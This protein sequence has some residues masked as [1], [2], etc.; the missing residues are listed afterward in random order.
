M[1]QGIT[2]AADRFAVWIEAADDPDLVWDDEPAAPDGGYTPVQNDEV[3]PATDM[4][5]LMPDGG[6]TITAPPV[7]IPN[8]NKFKTPANGLKKL[9]DTVDSNTD[10]KT[11]YGPNAHPKVQDW[12][13]KHPA[14]TKTYFK[15]DYQDALK[16]TLGDDNYAKLLYH[17][18]KP[19]TQALTTHVQHPAPNSN[20]FKTPANGLS[21]L[22][23]NPET[24]PEHVQAWVDKHPAFAKGYLQN[25]NYQDAI[26]GV[27]GE[28]NYKAWA[29][30]L[31]LPATKKTV[32]QKTQDI[33]DAFAPAGF[34]P[35][36]QDQFFEDHVGDS[37]P[38]PGIQG[39]M[40]PE[41]QPEVDAIKQQAVAEGIKAIFP[42]V[43]PSVAT[44]P[45]DQQ[46]KLLEGW[47]THL[48]ETPGH[49]DNLVKLKALYD[50]H[51][52]QTPQPAPVSPPA[53]PTAPGQPPAGQF[54]AP[55]LADE[56]AQIKGYDSDPGLNHGGVLWSGMSA[57]E[58]KSALGELLSDSDPSGQEG[59]ELQ[60]LYNKHFGPAALSP[61]DQAEA[62]A[63]KTQMPAAGMTPY[64]PDMPHLKKIEDAQPGDVLTPEFVQ[65]LADAKGMSATEWGALPY[66]QLTDI[67]HEYK[68]QMP[69]AT[70]GAK[71]VATPPGFAQ[72]YS[73][74]INEAPGAWYDE[75]YSA[76]L[77]LV[78]QYKQLKDYAN[79]PAEQP[80][81]PQYPPGFKAWVKYK[82][83]GGVPTD[84]NLTHWDG[85]TDKYKAKWIKKEQEDA[86]KPPF[87][88][89]GQDFYH[90]VVHAVDG[91]AQYDPNWPWATSTDPAEQ[92]AGLKEWLDSFST[93]PTTTE[94]SPKFKQVY[95]KYFGPYSD[96]D[97]PQQPS[98][99][100]KPHWW[101]GYWT[102]ALQHSIEN[103]DFPE[104][105]KGMGYNSQPA[106]LAQPVWNELAAHY[107]DLLDV[108]PGGD[109]YVPPPAPDAAQPVT[110]DVQL[111]KAIS[112][113]QLFD[114]LEK[115]LGA[116]TLQKK[117]WTGITKSPDELKEILKGWI[118]GAGNAGS[119]LK[120]PQLQ[121]AKDI[122]QKY[123]GYM[124]AGSGAAQQPA[125]SLPDWLDISKDGYP[126]WVDSDD[127][128][129]TNSY[130][131][132]LQSWEPDDLQY[133]AAHP[134]QAQKSWQ[135]H[136][137]EGKWLTP[138][139][140][141]KVEEGG[142]A[143]P[144]TS[145][146]QLW[147]PQQAKDDWLS[148]WTSDESVWDDQGMDDP[149][150]AKAYVEALLKDTTDTGYKVPEMKAWLAK[151]F[152]SGSPTPLSHDYLT[153]QLKAADDDV[154]SGDTLQN[155]L[156]SGLIE[157]KEKLQEMIAGG[158]D[159]LANDD[160]LYTQGEVNIYK[161]LLQQLSG[162]TPPTQQTGLSIGQQLKKI[163]N[164]YTGTLTV[165]KEVADAY[166]AKSPADL[167]NVIVNIKDAYPALA[168]KIQQ[169]Y[170]QHISGMAQS[171]TG[172]DPAAALAEWNTI[173]PNGNPTDFSSA[174]EAEKKVHEWQQKANEI[175]IPSP[176]LE[177]KK[178]KVQAFYDKWFGQ[179]VYE[180]PAATGGGYFK[181]SLEELQALNLKG[182][183]S[184]QDIS[185]QTEEEF[186]NNYNIV[187]KGL[188][189]GSWNYGPDDN[190]T[191][192]V[193]YIDSKGG[194]AGTVP[195]SGGVGWAKEY[196]NAVNWGAD[197]NLA[198]T[199]GLLFKDMTPEQAK[200]FLEKKLADG[201]YTADEQ[202][203]VQALYD[204]YFGSGGAAPAPAQ[205]DDYL[206]EQL[207]KADPSYWKVNGPFLKDFLDSDTQAKIQALKGYIGMGLATKE[208]NIYKQ[209]LQQLEG[210]MAAPAPTGGYDPVAALAE[211]KQIFPNAK[212]PDKFN[213]PEDA[214][215]WVYKNLNNPNANVQK[216]PQI[217]AFWDKWFGSGAG[218]EAAP[219]GYVSPGG[220][221]FKPSVDELKAL[222]PDNIDYAESIGSASDAD[223]KENYDYVKG[224]MAAG[225]WKFGDD[226]PWT[227]IVKYIDSKTPSETPAFAP[228]PPPLP[229]F[230]PAAFQVAYKAMFP[231]SGWDA[232]QHT[233]EQTKAKMH[234]MVQTK[235]NNF[236]YNPTTQTQIDLYEK[237]FG[238]FT[239]DST[240]KPKGPPPPPPPAPMTPDQAYAKLVADPENGKLF[241]SPEFKT[242]FMQNPAKQ[243]SW[244]TNP[245]L[246]AVAYEEATL[247]PPPPPMPFKSQPFKP[248]EL[249]HWAANKPISE[250]GW[251]NF[252]TWWANT[253]IPPEQEQAL[254]KAWFG[255]D[256]SP[257]QAG[258]WFQAMFELHAQPSEGDLGLQAG[259]LPNWAQSTWAF[260]PHAAQEWPV[261][262]A[263]ATKDPGIPAGTKIRQKLMIWNSLSPEDKQAI[264]DNYLPSD[265]VD[266]QAVIGEL[267]KAYPDSDW[268]A[269][270]QMGQ[271]TLKTN[272]R[273]LAESG[274]YPA[275]TAAFNKYFGGDIPMPKPGQKMKVKKAPVMKLPD[276]VSTYDGSYS[277]VTNSGFGKPGG[278][279]KFTD[280]YRWAESMGM[281]KMALGQE[282]DP[283][284]YN[285]PRSLLNDWNAI[286]GALKAAMKTMP[287][288]PWKNRDEFKQW[289]AATQ[290]NVRD[291]V[292]KIM[293]GKG[294]GF[295]PNA[296]SENK[297][298]L[299]KF[300]LAQE[301]GP[302]KQALL[303]VYNKHYGMTSDGT[304]QP[305]LA[306]TL[307]KIEP[308]PQ[309]VKNATDWDTYLQ[310]TPLETVAK[311]IKKKIKDEQDPDKFI[312]L[313]D[314]WSQ[315]F[316][317]PAGHK[318]FSS[319]LGQG[320]KGGTKLGTEDL[321]RLYQWKASGSP[322]T[323]LLTYWD[324][325]TYP[326]AYI[327]AVKA[328]DGRSVYGAAQ[329]PIYLGWTPP[330]DATSVDYT[331]DPALMGHS[332]PATTYDVPVL[333]KGQEYQSLLDSVN[334]FVP[335]FLSP[336]DKNVLKSDQFQNWF[337]NAS[338]AYKAQYKDHPGTAVS[339]FEK[340][341]DQ[342]GTTYGPV[343]G[344]PAVKP[345]VYDLSPFNMI[346]KPSDKDIGG[347][348]FKKEF[349]HNPPR[350]D[351]V[352]F[353]RKLDPQETLPLQPGDRW[354]PD[355]AAMPIYRLIPNDV[356]DLDATPRLS[357]RFDNL[358]PR[359]KE[360]QLELQRWRLRKIDQIIN[361]PN[362]KRDFASDKKYFDNW[363]SSHDITPD[364]KKDIE[365]T[366]FAVQPILSDDQ[367]WKY[368]EDWAAKNGVEPS[369]MYDLAS[370]VGVG[371][372]GE[373]VPNQQGNY[374][375]PELAQLILDYLEN[376]RGG[377]TMGG[378]LGGL[379]VHWTR[380]KDLLYHP[381]DSGM[382][383]ANA[384]KPGGAGTNVGG[385]RI[386]IYLWA[387][388]PGAG[389][390]S[391]GG[392]AY[393]ADTDSEL[394]H[395]LQQGAKVFLR[396]LQIRDEKGDFHDLID[397]GPIS[398]WA[399]GRDESSSGRD[400]Q[401]KES[402]AKR[403]DYDFP[404]VKH[405]PEEWDYLTPG[406]EADAKF[407]KL[408]EQYGLL[409]PGVGLKGEH[410]EYMKSKD[411]DHPHPEWQE[412]LTPKQQE[413]KK[414]LLKAYE[415]F[416][417]GKPHLPPPHFRFA[418]QSTRRVSAA[419][420]LFDMATVWNV[421]DAAK[422]GLPMHLARA[423]KPRP[424]PRAVAY[425][426]A[427]RH[428]EVRKPPGI[429]TVH[430]RYL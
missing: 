414:K 97:T 73:K 300:I 224:Q 341:I 286:P 179:G 247:P 324:N 184:L 287:V 99:Q 28:A 89:T 399:R 232:T 141:S 317:G 24:T 160:G 275:A 23:H 289:L 233:P 234:E 20:K 226:D 56:L 301:D 207:I 74:E 210:G 416:F 216:K 86:L 178:A 165:S 393:S 392:G 200:T 107:H 420:Q 122:Y 262:Q 408:F 409:S 30:D 139:D 326:S 176:Q 143:A 323:G 27:I 391:G 265:P 7:I 217:Q 13:D 208:T 156:D 48:A 111:V 152:G 72:W 426:H 186:K 180:A 277:V 204:K 347:H 379:G 303:G 246:A 12:L 415:H 285:W 352:K 298:R 44:M 327:D 349:T 79:P 76:K 101:K 189:D 58:A 130:Y 295:Y 87:A 218:S 39:E 288:F 266:T 260:G 35:K 162:Q 128:N 268:S 213:N 283:S 325:H 119:L 282:T 134:D 50:Q 185:S 137:T 425:A 21:K 238:P 389:E 132:W 197:P 62:D 66:A 108:A 25:P 172:Y 82:G 244:A 364:Q 158:E 214:K 403:L 114:D 250:A 243:I 67:A 109:H 1:P 100:T 240:T 354:A 229:P 344:D 191:K 203:N 182:P 61:D 144:A 212:F 314:V 53:A 125:A 92:Q 253:Q 334:T 222:F 359:Q 223:F 378:G 227:K 126:D 293:P 351:E 40:N 306:E 320:H 147:N 175:A 98:S 202:E 120:G 430:E 188:E 374:D 267:A 170:E 284:G 381:K 417:V 343:V 278:A 153:Q 336:H 427:D 103:S 77:E 43:D 150:S 149:L 177:E 83:F 142:P 198:N 116:G 387:L 407:A 151:Y 400:S 80:S 394:E 199:N 88:P 419:E 2:R 402:L 113:G 383:G 129:E 51:F 376:G 235:I 138:Q 237:W 252:S 18:P 71:P 361:G 396:R 201:G 337:E 33:A 211:W 146:V 115:T 37:G 264:A 280:F 309:G 322:P 375:S 413:I 256:T 385:R 94:L 26:K 331:P 401:D 395:M 388:W 91:D 4:P 302:Q 85:L 307:K 273:T 187:K 318:Q 274:A 422:Y 357:S 330:F 358:P 329:Q 174:V 34:V 338:D 377:D 312:A 367:K 281:G 423:P 263:W 384:M 348:K 16:A 248:D 93:S 292:E 371:N 231:G 69:Q 241:G 15:P 6:G 17:A 369:A 257:E 215:A 10:D 45:V 360:Y 163:V 412:G 219:A 308:T 332:A 112:E 196:A 368:F 183:N 173:F 55:A 397:P 194:A 316:Q 81:E 225:A 159:S 404:E 406:P 121:Q 166:D 305:T 145:R 296:S 59:A 270:A 11:F 95:E 313:C 63:I 418:S 131:S 276:W 49:K 236:G 353:P 167:Q 242:W 29:K 9:L 193:K 127:Y 315:F 47:A 41:D 31:K 421:R 161:K 373:G 64:E 290:G 230:D 321:G 291:D 124:G 171:P 110:S 362:A 46:K 261:F 299:E 382:G 424:K 386:P 3:L 8:S 133:W 5:G 304:V 254:Y 155:F 78:D 363:C 157:K 228:P 192:I 333:A 398:T 335:W 140:F 319:I 259:L 75:P 279:K 68:Q 239:P 428:V 339:D 366:I 90:D 310:T 42:N 169:A 410:P 429:V 340:F 328:E 70:G 57:D 390:S 255:K 38:Q 117:P 345:K 205:S 269:W 136:S 19:H 350:W 245:D 221:Y 168:D 206:T 209:L 271:G 104:F 251:K 102:P 123:F 65:W 32:E 294:S 135:Y 105:V 372:P 380:A 148:I 272:L 181:P 22:L 249:A 36:T 54:N 411:P 195:F 297:T 405:D 118:D 14:F 164:D 311:L 355:Y 342:G 365:N 356:L 106:D 96:P 370:K 258:A 60:A 154:W 190:W 52:G 346:P 84:K 220:T